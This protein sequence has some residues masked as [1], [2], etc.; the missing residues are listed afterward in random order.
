MS[1]VCISVA[2]YTYVFFKGQ[3]I[4]KNHFTFLNCGNDDRMIY[5]FIHKFFKLYDC[6]TLSR[7]SQMEKI[8]NYLKSSK[9]FPRK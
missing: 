4:S 2:F 3:N 8:Q 6:V 1:A 5:N 7:I 9:V